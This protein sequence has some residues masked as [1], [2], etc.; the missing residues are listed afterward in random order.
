MIDF[1]SNNASRFQA[2]AL[3]FQ[4]P[5][6]PKVQ[7]LP[8]SETL[9]LE[10]VME[11][12][13]LRKTEVLRLRVPRPEIVRFRGTS[14]LALVSAPLLLRR[15]ERRTRDVE[16][17]TDVRNADTFIF[18]HGFRHL[19]PWCLRIKRF[20]AAPASSCPGRGEAS[21]GALLHQPPLEL[22][23]GDAAGKTRILNGHNG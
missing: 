20:P 2:S 9:I 17:L 7:T 19:H 4:R 15:L 18:V 6:D 12:I 5:N 10:R 1:I 14:R 8:N 21:A 3:F 23:Q 11:R 22:R 13:S 16:G